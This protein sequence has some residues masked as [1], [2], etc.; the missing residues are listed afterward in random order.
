MQSCFGIDCEVWGGRRKPLNKL[1]DRELATKI[2]A[3]RMVNR[4]VNHRDCDDFKARE[5][6]AESI[7]EAKVFY[8][9]MLKKEN[10]GDI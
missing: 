3:E 6:A 8:E 9:E 10:H 5:V 1:Y 2:F 7:Q 4:H